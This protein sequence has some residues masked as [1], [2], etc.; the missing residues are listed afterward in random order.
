M[1]LLLYIVVILISPPLLLQVRLAL[2]GFLK[3]TLSEITNKKVQ[4]S[5][6]ASLLNEFV[7]KARAGVQISTTDINRFARL[8]KDELTMDNITRPQLASMCAFMGLR[9][10]G[11]DNFLRFQ[12]RAK[13]RNLKEDDQRIV[14]EG[15]DNLTTSELKEA[16]RVRTS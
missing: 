12:L 15:V 8:F 7:E 9:P 2:A 5:P 1:V 10:Y 6:N 16:C 4:D 3:D 13:L 14:W 11:G